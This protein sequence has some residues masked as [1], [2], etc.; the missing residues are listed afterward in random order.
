MKKFIYGLSENHTLGTIITVALG[1]ILIFF[2]ELVAN[3]VCYIAGIICLIAAG[4]CFFKSVALKKFEYSQNK[5][6][7]FIFCTLLTLG[8][9]LIIFQSKV[10][11]VLPLSA[12]IYLTVLGIIRA[13]QAF[14]SY[15]KLNPELF[16]K[17]LIPAIIDI[18]LGILMIVLRDLTDDII[19]QI[20]GVILLYNA[21]ES[22]IIRLLTKNF[23]NA[24]DETE[25]QIVA[26]FSDPENAKT[27]D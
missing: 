12:G 21:C 26:E 24:S 10:F 3:T 20:I 25:N 13:A 27:K 17:L 9:I 6:D 15:R 1:I 16:K 2:S 22:I 5:S 8:L 23:E 7:M 19:V 14:V 11:S 4:Y 18:V